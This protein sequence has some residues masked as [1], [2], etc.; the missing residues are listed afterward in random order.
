MPDLTPLQNMLNFVMRNYF[1]T[2]VN[3]RKLMFSRRPAREIIEQI[4][5]CQF[6]IEITLLFPG[7]QRKNRIHQNQLRFKPPLAEKDHLFPRKFSGI[8][9]QWGN[10]AGTK[11]AITRQRFNHLVTG[12]NNYYFTNFLVLAVGPG[13]Q[14]AVFPLKQVLTRCKFN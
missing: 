10:S 8:G 5:K 2:Q 13:Q 11:I 4:L 6:G 3:Q 14:P 7:R 12:V 1:S 9:G